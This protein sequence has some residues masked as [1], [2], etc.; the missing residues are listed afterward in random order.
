MVVMD[1]NPTD[2]DF[3]ESGVNVDILFRNPNNDSEKSNKC[4]ICDYAF[5]R[6]REKSYKCNQCD[7][8]SVYASSLSTHL[9]AHSGDKSNKCNQCDFACSDPSSL[10]EHLKKTLW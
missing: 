9:K 8:A 1:Q 2:N 10:R 7:F 3:S 6:K 5:S 4:N